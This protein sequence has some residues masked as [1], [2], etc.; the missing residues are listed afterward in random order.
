[1]GSTRPKVLST[2][3]IFAVLN[4]VYADVFTLFFNPSALKETASVTPT[5]ALVFAILMETS[6]AMV[7]LSR[8][9]KRGPNRVA[10]VVAGIFHTA[11]VGWSLLGQRPQPFY[12]FFA[13]VEIACTL[14]IVAYALRWRRDEPLA[15]GDATVKTN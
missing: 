7:V 13:C 8:V 15:V 10:N 1:M 9:L 14:F 5:A 2:L 11:F 4:Y 6:I 12:L 3:W